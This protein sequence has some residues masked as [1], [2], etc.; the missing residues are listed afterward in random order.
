[1]EEVRWKVIKDYTSYKI[2]QYGQVRLI[3][4]DDNIVNVSYQ[5]SYRGLAV[6][7]RNNKTNKAT[8]KAVRSLVY[9]HFIEDK[10]DIIISH[11]DGNIHNTYYKNLVHGRI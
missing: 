11:R 8:Y 7:L 9:K 1:M 10:G 2:N 6:K 3:G 5:H 4:D